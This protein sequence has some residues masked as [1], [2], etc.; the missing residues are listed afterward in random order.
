LAQNANGRNCI[1]GCCAARENIVPQYK[2]GCLA[3]EQ[4]EEK[5]YYFRNPV[6]EDQE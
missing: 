1:I 5:N 3:L 2:D 6:R 4:G